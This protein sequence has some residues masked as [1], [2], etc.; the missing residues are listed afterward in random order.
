MFLSPALPLR[1]LDARAPRT[2]L[3]RFPLI[4]LSASCRISD[5]EE[6]R[7]RRRLIPDPNNWPP[8]HILG[9]FLKNGE[10]NLLIMDIYS[11]A[12]EEFK[13]SQISIGELHNCLIPPRALTADWLQLPLSSAD[14][15]SS[16]AESSVNQTL[17][18]VVD[19][20][21]A[22]GANQLEQSNRSKV[23]RKARNDLKD[24]PTYE[25]LKTVYNPSRQHLDTFMKRT[26]NFPGLE[27][28]ILQRVQYRLFI[29]RASPTP[30][31]PVSRG[32]RSRLAD[33]YSSRRPARHQVRQGHK[34]HRVPTAAFSRAPRAVSHRFRS[35]KLKGQ[36]LKAVPQTI[37]LC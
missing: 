25:E 22:V 7:W 6:A 17:E 28:L 31:D 9:L 24:L 3:F 16:S 27:Q 20:A 37:S 2:R 10:A 19:E 36:R 32:K 14:V 34:Q 5:A 26:F 30:F 8:G 4:N 1:L 11:Q 12:A 13:N 23:K 35:A 29:S 21:R 18:F 15:S 33:S